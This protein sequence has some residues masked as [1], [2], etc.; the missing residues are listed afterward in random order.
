ML[1]AFKK[2]NE[3]L[4]GISKSLEDYLETKRMVFPR[5]YFLSNDELLEILAQ[6]CSQ[7][8][9]C[10]VAPYCTPT[11]RGF[12]DLK[13]YRV[14]LVPGRCKC[15]F[16]AYN[17]H[18]AYIQSSAIASSNLIGPSS[19]EQLAAKRNCSTRICIV[20]VDNSDLEAAGS[21]WQVPPALLDPGMA[22][23]L[24]SIGVCY[25]LQGLHGICK[26]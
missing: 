9:Y 3:V 17:N 23:L 11:Q 14:L 12:L 26:G 5:F 18:L 1:E 21:E 25:C 22:G 20:H 4:E 15:I 6:V 7:T 13:L 16:S 19:F 10:A 2:S 24:C 8:Q